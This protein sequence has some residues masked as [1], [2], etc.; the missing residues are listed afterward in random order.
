MMQRTLF[1]KDSNCPMKPF[2]HSFEHELDDDAD[3]WAD[4][5]TLDAYTAEDHDLGDFLSD[6]ESMLDDELLT[7]EPG[8]GHVTNLLWNDV[9]AS[10]NHVPEHTPEHVAGDKRGLRMEVVQE[11]DEVLSLCG[12]VGSMVVDELMDVA[13]YEGPE[14]WLM[15]AECLMQEADVEMEMDELILIQRKSRRNTYAQA[16]KT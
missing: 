1:E 5:S 16:M 15:P 6:D 14:Q 11:E 7:P 3:I 4:W 12:S 9:G 13:S 10:E 8:A 2:T